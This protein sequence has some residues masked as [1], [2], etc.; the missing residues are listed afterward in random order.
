MKQ[1]IGWYKMEHR[2]H[3]VMYTVVA[4]LTLIVLFIVPYAVVYYLPH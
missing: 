2:Y 3:A 1:F 4:A